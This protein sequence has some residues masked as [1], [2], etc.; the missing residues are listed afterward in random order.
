AGQTVITS[1]ASGISG[2][3]TGAAGSSITAGVPGGGMLASTGYDMLFLDPASQET[4]TVCHHDGVLMTASS[5]STTST[6]SI[7]GVSPGGVF[8]NTTGTV[9]SGALP[10]VASV[11]FADNPGGN[12]TNSAP[13]TFIVT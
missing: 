2:F 3:P 13:A 7:P 4:A 6:A 10:G 9:P 5:R 12:G 8:N 1:P 11:C